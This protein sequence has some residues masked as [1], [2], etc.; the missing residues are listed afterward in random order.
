[1]FTHQRSKE[2]FVTN[3]R[4]KNVKRFANDVVYGTVYVL[5]DFD[6]YIRNLDAYHMCS[7]SALRKNH[8]F[9]V[10]HRI[11]TTVTPI[12]FSTIEELARIKY[13]EGKPIDAHM[14]IGNIKHPKI[15][16][17]IYNIRSYRVIDGVDAKHIKQ[18]IREVLSNE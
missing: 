7:L 12:Y 8:Q 15:R 1:M 3:E 4:V 5:S 10:H 2:T 16:K 17:R 11:L 9:D 18:R 13:R 6:Y 14:Y